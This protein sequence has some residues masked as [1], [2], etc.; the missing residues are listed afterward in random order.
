M[1]T[2]SKQWF[3]PSPQSREVSTATEPRHVSSPRRDGH[4]PSFRVPLYPFEIAGASAVF[5]VELRRSPALPR[6]FLYSKP[7]ASPP[8]APGQHSVEQVVSSPPLPSPPLPST[9][10]DCTPQYA[11]R[12]G[13]APLPSCQFLQ[14]SR[15]N[16]PTL[17]VSSFQARF[18]GRGHVDCS[19]FSCIPYPPYCYCRGPFALELDRVHTP[20]TCANQDCSLF[21]DLE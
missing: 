13:S 2:R 20:R 6:V 17:T 9:A 10:H 12:F 4:P 18:H 1:L 11:L 5:P 21:A 3:C 16:G 14:R 19:V 8:S 7:V 15:R